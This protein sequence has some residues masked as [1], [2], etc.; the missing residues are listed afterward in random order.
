M[1]ARDA[2]IDVCNIGS[3]RRSKASHNIHHSIESQIP[4]VGSQIEWYQT[5]GG[6]SNSSKAN[7]NAS[8]NAK[9]STQKEKK[10]IADT[11]SRYKLICTG[12]SMSTR[13][14][15]LSTLHIHHT[16][17]VC[18]VVCDHCTYCKLVKMQFY[19]IFQSNAY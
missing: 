18:M 5:R 19:Y 14:H 16:Q 12:T 13:T 15:T 8:P 9:K 6:M 4:R 11:R 7:S 17:S 1:Y 3:K 2:R 10:N